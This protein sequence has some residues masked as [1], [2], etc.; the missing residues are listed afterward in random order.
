MTGDFRRNMDRIF[1]GDAMSYDDD[2][3]EDTV[4]NRR[5]VVRET[6]RPMTWEELKALGEERFPVA[7]DP[8]CERFESFLRSHTHSKFYRAETPE[9]AEVVYCRDTMQGLW[10]LP[11]SGMGIIQQRG[12]DFL[13]EIVDGQ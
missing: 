7:T 5:K 4:G 11:G 2:W 3:T 13:R 9:G 8:W 1:T 6:L 10:F 12:L